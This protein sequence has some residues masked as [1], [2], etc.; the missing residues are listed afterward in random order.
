MNLTARILIAIVA[1]MLIMTGCQKPSKQEV[2]LS[3]AVI[4]QAERENDNIRRI[5][6]TGEVTSIE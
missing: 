4:Q 1:C 5:K 3:G 2:V 6:I